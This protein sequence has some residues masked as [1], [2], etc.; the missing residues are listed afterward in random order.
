MR[1]KEDL[2][3]FFASFLAHNYDDLD[4]IDTYNTFQS[5]TRSLFEKIGFTTI[6]NVEMA[7][8]QHPVVCAPF[9]RGIV[10][11]N[12]IEKLTVFR[13]L[14]N[15]DPKKQRTAEGEYVY[16][17]LNKRNNYIKIGKSK[18]PDFREKTLQAEEPDIQLITVWK[19]PAQKER[20]LHARF[21]A[22]RKRG[23]WF[24][25]NLSDLKTI[26]QL[27]AAYE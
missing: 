27:M 17:M 7:N 10:Q 26:K 13:Q 14:F 3:F 9:T 18:I 19:A 23:E 8:F 6:T 4:P 5:K 15:Y 22:S 25:L 24:K 16:L 20:D 2:T 11:I 1:E 12:F 21:T